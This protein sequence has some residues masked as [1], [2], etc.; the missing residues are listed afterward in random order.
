MDE[1]NRREY[2][3]ELRVVHHRRVHRVR[4]AAE[5]A[6]LLQRIY[7]LRMV[8]S[9]DE[10]RVEMARGWVP[11]PL[12]DLDLELQRQILQARVDTLEGRRPISPRIPRL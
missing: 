7:I 12:P 3:R 11:P 6:Y 8:L 2:L 1:R 9:T 5:E 4:S 10:E